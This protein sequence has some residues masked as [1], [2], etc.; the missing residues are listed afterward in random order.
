MDKIEVKTIIPTFLLWAF[1]GFDLILLTLTSVEIQ[2]LYFPN[3]DQTVSILAVYGTLSLSLLGRVFGGIYFSRLADAHGRKPI[4][5]L[6]LIVLSMTS[7]FSAFLPNIYTN[8]TPLPSTVIPILF[9]VTRIIIGFFIGGI[10]PTAAVLG[11]EV[12]SANRIKLIFKNYIKG[13]KKFSQTEF[14]KTEFNRKWINYLQNYYL[15][16]TY[17]NYFDRETRKLTG[18]SASMQIGF[19]TG[20]FV[21]ASL[22]YNNIILPYYNNI[23]SFGSMSLMAGIFGLV[24][25]GFYRFLI[26]ESAYWKFSKYLYEEQ[27][28]LLKVQNDQLKE[29]EKKGDKMEIQALQNIVY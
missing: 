15:F 28:D 1:A 27:E 5:M 17:E 13:E 8:L 6:C 19:F 23:G 18:K 14:S 21:A 9:V 29:R 12:I 2:K 26:P 11:L 10:W 3:T 22:F 24:I 7:L 25:F 16:R 4:V 20:Y